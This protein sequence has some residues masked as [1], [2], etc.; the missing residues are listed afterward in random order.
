MDFYFND[1]DGIEIVLGG[2]QKM[3][4][5]SWFLLKPISNTHFT[6]YICINHIFT[7][8]AAPRTISTSTKN[9][10]LLVYDEVPSTPTNTWSQHTPK[11][12]RQRRHKQLY[13]NKTDLRRLNKKGRNIRNEKASRIGKHTNKR[14][15]KTT[16]TKQQL[17]LIQVQI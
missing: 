15:E 7:Y 11:M 16:Y 9:D 2:V 17:E 8:A 12:L 5:Y 13:A 4:R 10:I 1:G 3:S 14:R 6:H